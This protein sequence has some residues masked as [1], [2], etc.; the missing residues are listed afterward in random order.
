LRL[1]VV[2][3]TKAPLHIKANDICSK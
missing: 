2:I 3:I 1:L